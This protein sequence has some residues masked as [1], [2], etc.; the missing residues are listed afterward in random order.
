MGLTCSKCGAG[1]GTD[2]AWYKRHLKT[3]KKSDKKINDTS[4]SRIK[5]L[6]I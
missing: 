4:L 6:N 3:H 1:F 5:R 2:K